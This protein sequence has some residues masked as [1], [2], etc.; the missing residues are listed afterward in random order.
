[1]RFISIL[2]VEFFLTLTYTTGWEMDDQNACKHF[3]ENIYF[4]PIFIQNWK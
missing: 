4:N 3:K 1:M 2:I